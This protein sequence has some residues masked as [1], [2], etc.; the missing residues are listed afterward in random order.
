MRVDLKARPHKVSTISKQY[1]GCEP[2]LYKVQTAD[3][4]HLKKPLKSLKVR[5]YSKKDQTAFQSKLK[6]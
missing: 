2:D 5:L 1:G 6:T 4:V 3:Y